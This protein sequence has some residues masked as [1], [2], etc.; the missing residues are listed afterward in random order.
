MKAWGL[1]ILK[2]CV[3]VTLFIVN[4]GAF[5]ESF[6]VG[7][8]SLVTS[9]RVSLYAYDYTYKAALTNAGSAVTDVSAG[10]TSLSPYITVLEGNLTFGTVAASATVV[11]SD[12]FIVRHDRRGTFDTTKLVWDVKA[13]PALVTVP[14]VTGQTKDNAQAALLAAGLVIGTITTNYSDTV[15]TNN[16]VSQD[17]PAGNSVAPGTAVKLVVSLGQEQVSIPNVV[18]MSQAAATAAIQSA[19]CSLGSISTASSDVVPTGQVITQTPP[20]GTATISGAVVSLVISSGSPPLTIPDVIGLTQQSANDTLKAKGFVLG[21][22]TNANSAIVTVGNIMSQNPAVGTITDKGVAVAVVVSLGPA[23]ATATV[24]ALVGTSQSQAQAAISTAGLAVGTLS[25]DYSNSVPSGTIIS[26]SPLSGSKAITGSK[27]SLV[28]SMGPI[29]TPPIPADPATVAPPVDTTVATTLAASTAFLY[30]GNNPIQTGVPEGTIEVKRAAVLRGKVMDRDNQ[31]LS[32]VNIT[33]KDHPEF[34]QTFTRTDG[35]FDLAVNGGGYLTVNYRKAEFLPVQRQI[36][37]PWNDFVNIDDVV[38]VSLDPQV[39][40]VDLTSSVPVQVVRGSVMNDD[41]GSRQGTLLVPQGTGASIKLPNGSSQPL[42]TLNIRVTEYTVGENGPNAMPGL[43]PPTSGYTYAMELSADEALAAGATSVTFAEPLYYYVENFVGIPVGTQVPV[44]Y[45]DAQKAA[46][47]PCDDGRVIKIVGI[48][49]GL[50]ALDLSGNGAAADS[51]ALTALGVTDAERQQLATLYTVGQTLWRVPIS[52]FSP[53]DLNY[54]IGPQQPTSPD[55]PSQQPQN[56]EATNEPVNDPNCQEGSIIGCEN[57]TLAEVVPIEGTP[58]SLHYQSERT[59]GYIN[60]RNLDIPLSGDALP[61]FIKRID[62]TVQIAGKEYFQSF[63]PSTNLRYKFIWDGIDSYGREV[64]DSQ[65]TVTIS[66]IYDGYYKYPPSMTRTFGQTGTVFSVPVPARQEI[67]LKQEYSKSLTISKN[68]G[69]GEWSLNVRH[70]YDQNNRTLHLGDGGKITAQSSLPKV[71]TTVAGGGANGVAVASDGS[72]YVTDIYT[73]RIQRI[74]PAGIITT[75]AGNGSSGYSGDGGPATAAKLLLPS[76]VAV[77]LDGSVYITDGMVRIRRIGPDGIITTIAGNGSYGYSGDGGPATAAM[78]FEPRGVAVTQDGNVYF[79]DRENDRIRRIGPDGIITTVAGNGRHGYS[80]DGG[81]ATAA[82]LYSPLG[83]AV[84]S[85]GSVYFSDNGNK[86]IRHIGPDGIITTVAGNGSRGYSGDGGPATAASLDSP[87]SVA[88]ASDGS[89]YFSDIGNNRI[90]RIGS[91]GIITTFAGNGSRGYSGDGGPA[92]AASLFPWSVAVAPNGDLYMVGS[93]NG[94]RQVSN[95]YPGIQLSDHLIPSSD[96]TEVYHFNSSGQHL[97]TLNALTGAPIYQFGYD[98]HGF[99]V[100]VTDADGNIT[101]IERDADGN[102]VAII[103]PHGQRTTLTLDGNGYLAGIINPNGEAHTMTYSNEGLMLSFTD[104]KGNRSEFSYDNSGLLIKDENAAGGFKALSTATKGSIKYNFLDTALSRRTIYTTEDLSTGDQERT[105][106]YPFG[107]LQKRSIGTNGTTTTIEPDGTVIITT[108]G[109]DPRFGMQSPIQSSQT[110]KTPGGLTSTIQQLRTSN[111]ATAGNP[112][113]LSALTDTTTING[114]VYQSIFNSALKEYT[115]TT[116]AKRISKTIIDYLGR[117]LTLMPDPDILL[118]N[119]TYDAKGQLTETV[120]GSSKVRFGYD[121][122]GRMNSST[123]PLGG[124]TL[125]DHDVASRITKLTRPSGYSY[126]FTYDATGN[127]TSITMPSGVVHNLS[128]NN[129]NLLSSYTPPGNLPYLWEYSLDK[130]LVKAT[131]PSGREITYDYDAGGRST[132]LSYPEAT[133]IR[134]Y[135]DHTNRVS[136]LIRS[137]ADGGTVQGISFTYDGKLVTSRTFS[138]V[139]NG[140]FSYS[141]DNNFSLTGIT[142][143]SGAETVSLPIRRDADGLV[144][145]FGSFTYSRGGPAGATTGI[146]DGTMQVTITYDDRGRVKSRAHTVNG[147]TIYNIELTYDAGGQ[148]VSRNENLAGN[149]IAHEYS[150]DADGQL[151]QAKKGDISAEE[152]SYDANGNRTR[153]RSGSALDA[154]A[155]YDEQDRLKN[156]GSIEYQFDDDGYLVKK[157]RDLY[158]YSSKGELLSANLDGLVVNYTYDGMHRRVARTDPAGTTQYLYGDP[159]NPFQLTASRDPEGVLTV[160]HYDMEN[161]LIAF[162][163]GGTQYYVASDQIGSPRAITDNSGELVKFIEY[164]SF[165][166]VIY[167]SDPDFN[168]PIGFAGGINDS[169]TGLVRFGFRDYDA[170]AGRW[171]AKDPILFEGSTINLFI[172]TKN[173]PINYVDRNGLY[174]SLEAATDFDEIFDNVLD[175]PDIYLFDLSSGSRE[176]IRNL[177][178]KA[179]LNSIN[180]ESS[181]DEDVNNLIKNVLLLEKIFSTILKG[182]N[183]ASLLV[184]LIDYYNQELTKDAC[185]AVHR[186]ITPHTLIEDLLNSYYYSN[187]D[188]GINSLIYRN[189]MTAQ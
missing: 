148:I 22:V 5:A 75:I 126:G 171:T 136:D 69:L 123:N 3:I 30:S 37:V 71:I 179:I 118:T 70:Y 62:L 117:P 9:K 129:V 83:V 114:R 77:A 48:V 140:Q 34:G 36:N 105:V 13:T 112:L 85:D 84:A 38:L 74:D 88:V 46:W 26:Q 188:V 157:G 1:W 163:R 167:D 31:P 149:P 138:G 24:P 116:P 181:L 101:T 11:S 93:N 113:S 100:A 169:S 27:V 2:L 52:H 122:F 81:P 185:K 91:N 72:V 76:S 60:N 156:L 187:N 56:D 99:L 125:Y 50:A 153:Y 168:L 45:Y 120:Q 80:G 67:V 130:E 68:A 73:C 145:A 170:W 146:T 180:S 104:P 128:Y 40:T 162:E 92:T 142:L 6:T 189:F 82:S 103:A 108:E 51:T 90:R 47:V 39:T 65:A 97:R 14:E 109:P 175:R 94:I 159:E 161:R 110:I 89:V 16:I 20:G 64:G 18:G 19:R 134:Q 165:G 43:L 158:T 78:I 44:G 106:T 178:V 86:R 29:N 131:L 42:S 7:N 55:S 119:F 53:Y 151:V 111:L 28:V 152:Y 186:T 25:Q 66:Y 127:R 121:S 160:Y 166:N 172:Y 183:F 15:P 59:K 32:G 182:K 132:G 35:M 150:Y 8:Y 137:P 107:G 23:L 173:N 184:S 154:V 63:A 177:I 143:A 4:G 10:L 124:A 96:S 147:K 79:A 21:S 87:L 58:F 135:H 133:I 164:Q 57:Q 139:A 115:N 95:P 155:E 176:K 98:D 174:S 144:N 33:V 17:P 49:D 61:E 12:T 54:G 141:Y 102:P 41:S